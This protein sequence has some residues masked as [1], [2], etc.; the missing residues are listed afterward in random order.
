MGI[1][2]SLEPGLILVVDDSEPIRDLL[3][4]Q[5][6][7]LGHEVVLASDGLEAI[8]QVDTRFF[9]LILTDLEMPRLNGFQLLGHLKGEPRYHDIPVIVITGHGELEDITNS[10]RLGAEDYLCCPFNRTLLKSKVDTCLEKQRLRNRN[11]MLN[12]RHDELHKRHD[13]LH[14][15]HDE[16]LHRILPGPIVQEL[17]VTNDVKSR[18]HEDVAVMVTNLVGFTNYCDHIQ[19]HPEVVVGRLRQ[20]FEESQDIASGFRV[21]KIKTFGDSFM[22]A[23]GLLEEV[24]N[25]VL[26]CVR[27]GLALIKMARSMS[28]LHGAPLGWDLRVGIHVGPVVAGLLGRRQLLYDLWGDTVNLAV[29][30][31][32]HGRPGCV[33]LSYAA[34]HRVSEYYN[35]SDITNISLKGKPSPMEIFHL[36]PKY[37]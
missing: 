36:V 28:D 12:K 11:D 6:L 37:A 35:N 20:F 7:E 21:Q 33:N 3:R 15:R 23:A 25:P 14:K 8:K 4:L 22:G 19:D 18:L 9:D 32:G 10:I 1:Q 27:C 2:A 17:T 24:E 34:W 13:E 5:L 16:L 29:R 26:D 30:L 31:E